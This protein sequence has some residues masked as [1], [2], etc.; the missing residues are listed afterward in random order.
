RISIHGHTDNVGSETKN[1]KL[2][3]ERAREVEAFLIDNGISTKRLN[4]QGFGS[5]KPK[6]GNNNEANRSLNRRVEF[7]ILSR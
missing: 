7:V 2:S 1:L 3:N 4:H 6:K 5:S